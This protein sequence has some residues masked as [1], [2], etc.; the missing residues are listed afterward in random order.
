MHYGFPVTI[1]ELVRYAIEEGVVR[2]EVDGKNIHY[3]ATILAAN[4]RLS[5][6]SS[7]T[8][9]MVTPKVF[10]DDRAVVMTIYTNY[11]MESKELSDEE[12]EDLLDFIACELDLDL[13]MKP[14]WFYDINDPWRPG[15]P[16]D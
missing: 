15:D 2:R 6:R 4:V 1:D 3:L 12:E 14:K 13:D 8:V 9:N 11:T 16:E 10:E 5:E 7:Y